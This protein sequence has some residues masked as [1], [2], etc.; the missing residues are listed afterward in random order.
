MSWREGFILVALS[1]ER[2]QL[3]GGI[4]RAVL[5]VTYVEGYDAHVVARYEPRVFFSVIEHEGED[6]VELVDEV[7]A[8]EL[9]EGE[10]DFAVAASLKIVH[11][12]QFAS[13]VLMVVYLA[14]HRQHFLAVG[15]EERLL[16]RQGVNDSQS[17]VCQH[18]FSVTIHPAPVGTAVPYLCRHS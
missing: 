5:V 1:L 16:A 14:I 10:D 12:S 3:A 13:Q 6:A 18:G 8:I 17:L 11:A 7:G 9:V 4:Y 2:L 15:R